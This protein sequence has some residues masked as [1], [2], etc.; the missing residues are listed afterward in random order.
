M[1]TLTIRTDKPEAEIG[2]YA[3]SQPLAYHTWEAHRKL[4]ETIHSTIKSLLDDHGKTLK[5]INAVAVFKGPGSFTG[6]RIGCSVANALADSLRV[7]VVAANGEQW[8]YTAL[9]RLKAGENERVALPNYGAP[10]RTT[11]QKK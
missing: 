2:L 3:N 4:A 11:A 1:L 5:D 7:P 10:P 8:I 9:E 6:L